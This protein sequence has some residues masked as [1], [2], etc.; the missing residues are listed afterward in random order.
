MIEKWVFFD[1]DGTLTRSEEG[2]WNCVKY[3]AERMGF[4]V[5]DAATLRKFIGPPLMWSFRELAGMTARI[6]WSLSARASEAQETRS[7]N[8]LSPK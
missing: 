7:I 6:R 3:T 5:P 8:L 1:L 2:I 4:P